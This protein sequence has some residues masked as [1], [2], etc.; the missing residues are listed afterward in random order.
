MIR[1]VVPSMLMVGVWYITK[2][3]IIGLASNVQEISQMAS[4]ATV[5]Q[6]ST[7]GKESDVL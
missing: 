1:V 6:T 5:L 4:A 2:V 3:Y 7:H